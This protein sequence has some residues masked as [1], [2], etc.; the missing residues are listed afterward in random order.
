MMPLGFEYGPIILEA[1][2]LCF[3]L[4]GRDVLRD[5]SFV[6]RDLRCP[7]RVTGQVVALLGPSGIGKTRL[8]R[9]LAGLEPPSSG[10][11]RIGEGRLP[12]RRGLVGLVAQSY[13]LFAH[14]TVLGNLRVAGGAAGLPGKE[15]LA[16]ARRLLGRMQ[17]AD[18]AEAYPAE[19][20]GGQR[21]RVAIAQQLL[22]SE[23]FVLMDEPFSG[24][25]PLATARII[26]LIGEVAGLHELNTIV[27][28]THDVGAAIAV[29]DTLLLMG[30]DRDGE[31]RV[32][33]GARI[34]ATFDLVARGLVGR[35]RSQRESADL[36]AEVLAR[37]RTL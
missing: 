15:A 7:G 19:L 36:E 26:D 37:F 35:A 21:Q 14:R 17:L 27:V 33:P 13:P 31:G 22:C 23:H 6:V 28:A 34:Q 3:A 29:A 32:V 16:R 4:D 20:S 11:V 9:L 25:D 5:V 24:L 2:R 10:A 8:L 1:E 30:C 12:A 18:R